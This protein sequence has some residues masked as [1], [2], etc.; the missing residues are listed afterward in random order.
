MCLVFMSHEVCYR[1]VTHGSRQL[2]V[3]FRH[4]LIPGRPVLNV[5]NI[6]SFANTTSSDLLF[7]HSP[8]DCSVCPLIR[9]SAFKISTRYR[10]IPLP[11]LCVSSGRHTPY[12]LQNQQLSASRWHS[13]ST[14]HQP[15][16]LR[17][18]FRASHALLALQSPPRQPRPHLSLCQPRQTIPR[19]VG[20][21]LP[22]R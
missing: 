14:N 8:L 2:T 22:S 20:Q 21:C 4:N 15:T 9:F 11:P 13:P 5:A 19:L 3:E 7:Q 12:S 1:P 16:S 18:H 10:Y 6:P 17:R